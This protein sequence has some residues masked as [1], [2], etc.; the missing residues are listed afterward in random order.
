MAFMKFGFGAYSEPVQSAKLHFYVS[1]DSFSSINLT[2][3]SYETDSWDE[4]TMNWNNR[5][6][7]GSTTI[8][9][10]NVANGHLPIL[11]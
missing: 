8:G 2:V 9:T 3:Y 5:L 6:G 1:E 10:V 4:N 11:G 7:A